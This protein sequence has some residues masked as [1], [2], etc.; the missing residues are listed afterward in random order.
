MGK[1]DNGAYGH[2]SGKI[3]NLVSYTL[4]GTNVIRKIGRS[5]KPPTNAQRAVRKKLKL[6][7][8]FLNPIFGFIK[9]GFSFAAECTGKYPHNVAL[10]YNIKNAMAGEYPNI[11]L[12]Y[13]KAMVSMGTLTPA[14]NP[15]VSKLE[16]GIEFTWEVASD[17]DWKIKNDRAMLLL[18]FPDSSNA[19]YFLSGA[20]RPEGK[21]FM[22]LAPAYLSEVMQCYIAFYADDK[23]SLSDSVWAGAL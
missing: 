18:Y 19:I 3:G 2:V 14:I 6:V 4:N 21:D 1:L 7:N 10:S 5:T 16:N 12:D 20:K 9:V 17:M 11:T 22:E 13:S 8:E 15:V 23:Q